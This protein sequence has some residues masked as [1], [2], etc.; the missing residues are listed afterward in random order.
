MGC[1]RISVLWIVFLASA[2]ALGCRNQKPGFCQG[3]S[4]CSSGLHCD[5]RV[6]GCV[7]ADA[8]VG[9]SSGTGGSGGNAGNGGNAGKGGAGGMAACTAS[10]CSGTT[11][12][13]D[14]T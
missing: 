7:S 13:C 6:M 9:G 10:S 1:R 4:D 3:D 14:S 2:F 12:V 5:L 8:G 11:P